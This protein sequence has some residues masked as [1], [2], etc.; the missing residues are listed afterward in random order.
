MIRIKWIAAVVSLSLMACG[1]EPEPIELDIDKVAVEAGLSKDDYTVHENGVVEV[2]AYDS[3][4]PQ[5]KPKTLW[6]QNDLS[7]P[8]ETVGIGEDKAILA[9]AGLTAAETINS[10]D[11]E[12]EPKKTYLMNGESPISTQFEHSPNFITLTWY[13]FDNEPSSLEASQCS[14]KEAYKIARAMA[15]RE[16]ADAVMYIS[17]G[18]KYRSKPVAGYETTGQCNSGICFF[19][20]T[21]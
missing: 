16:G 15:G 5:D 2:H 17:N 7:S 14:L 18:G 12:G 20:M 11:P 8:I 4:T 19:T 13:Q 21:L 10:D 1:S 6:Y 9:S 3:D